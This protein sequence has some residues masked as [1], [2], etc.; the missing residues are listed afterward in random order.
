[1]TKSMAMALLVSVALAQTPAA[2]QPTPLHP[3]QPMHICPKGETWQKGCLK[4]APA[5][6]GKLFGQCLKQGYGCFRAPEPIQ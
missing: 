6:P 1:M 5:P 2:A 4:W 3:G